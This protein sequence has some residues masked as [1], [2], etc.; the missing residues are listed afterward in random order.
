MKKCWS[1]L[2]GV[3]LIASMLAFLPTGQAAAEPQ[4][5]DA[6][7][8]PA[9]VQAQPA[10][11]VSVPAQLQP[12]DPFETVMG[13]PKP[14][15]PDVAYAVNNT[16]TGGKGRVEL[17]TSIGQSDGAMDWRTSNAWAWLVYNVPKNKHLYLAIYNTWWDG[18]RAKRDK[19]T[20]K[21]VIY[22]PSGVAT[23]Q[24][25][26]FTMAL[27][28]QINYYD[29]DA[30]RRQYIWAVGQRDKINLAKKTGSSLADLVKD[31]KTI[32]LC[33]NWG[34]GCIPNEKARDMHS[35]F[36]FF[37]QTKDSNGRLWDNVVWVTTGNLNGTSG[38][39]TVNTAVAVYGDAKLYKEAV[40]KVVGAMKAQA[41]TA[42][43][44]TIYGTGIKGD[45][46]GV[47]YIPSPRK[48]TDGVWKDQ[49]AEVMQA[50][51][52]ASKKGCKVRVL[53]AMFSAGR[54]KFFSALVKA[55]AQGC[56]V[57][58]IL[59]EDFV[60]NTAMVYFT[61]NKTMRKVLKNIAYENIHEKTLAISNNGKYTFFTGSANMN[62][63]ALSSD[64]SVIRLDHKQ[65]VVAEIAH[66]DWVWDRAKKG[67]T[68]IK[69]ASVKIQGAEK[70]LYLGTTMQLKGVIAPSN[71]TKKE[72][73]WTSSNKAVATVDSKGKVTPKKPGKVTIKATSFQGGKSASVVI[74]VMENNIVPQ[75][76]IHR[77]TAGTTIGNNATLTID[78][79]NGEKYNGKVALYY[80][81]ASSGREIWVKEA[82]LNVVNGV[83]TYTYTVA[84]NRTWQA[85]PMPITSPKPLV[86]WDEDDRFYSKPAAVLGLAATASQTPVLYV[87]NRFIANQIVTLAAQWDSPNAP[88]KPAELELQYYK[89][90]KWYTKTTFTIPNGST[91]KKLTIKD[92]VSRAW[93]LKATKDSGSS[94]VSKNVSLRLLGT[95]VIPKPKV[96][97]S[98]N[99]FKSG[100]KV[101]FTVTWK[102]PYRDSYEG[103]LKLQYYDS[104]KWKT[105]T[106]I[107]IP[108]NDTQGSVTITLKD[109]HKWRVIP[110][111]D[112]LPAGLNL[113]ASTIIT[114]S[115]S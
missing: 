73:R 12:P 112:S 89:S 16:A 18:Y 61:M 37:E 42:D 84:G 93:R 94:A 57:R 99:P 44:R 49:E 107:T 47:T 10:G 25:P 39:K 7:V 97:A 32:L 106:S 72:I 6:Q 34:G 103:V 29:T 52:K 64:E 68:K 13:T 86:V 56:S 36:A 108:K 8:Q 81:N 9:E 90:G 71:A 35:K 43:Y 104:G 83:A 100:Q 60:K 82:E 30:E 33:T 31:T 110:T 109:S 69:V 3:A 75:P 24:G 28:K 45:L 50:L 48:R 53:N 102:N 115:K 111:E 95:T 51:T 22:D 98:P 87:P 79:A 2:L 58:V 14:V 20:N 1:W 4:P 55:K 80:L 91:V 23:T 88:A 62:G 67:S 54:E 101:T 70:T 46:S 78:W 26:N 27:A 76:T 41:Y 63:V 105:N 17:Y 5:A 74:T 11:A 65:A 92:T 15:I 96:T 19:A 66:A 40:Q 21:F 59:D 77:S 113:P 85:R 114:V 38:G